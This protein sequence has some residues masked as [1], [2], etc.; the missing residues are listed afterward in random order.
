[1][2]DGIAGVF[3]LY[4]KATEGSAMFGA[5]EGSAMFGTEPPKIGELN[6]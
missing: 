6:E 4:S 5:T 3:I 2:L 1:M